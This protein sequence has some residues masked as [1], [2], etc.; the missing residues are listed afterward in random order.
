[1]KPFSY[2][3]PR[4]LSGALAF[5]Q[6]YGNE[7]ILVAGGT[8][9]IVRMKRGMASPH[10]LIDI[11]SISNL[12]NIEFNERDG[13]TIGAAA[14]LAEIESNF[15]IQA[16][17]PL[18]ADAARVIGSWQTRNLGTIGGNICNAS[19]A[20]DMIPALIALRG[21]VEIVNQEGARWAD[22]EGF[23][24]GP[25]ESILRDSEIVTRIHIP[26]DSS[27]MHGTYLKEARTRGMDLATVG[28]AVAINFRD[29][30]TCEDVSIVLGAVAPTPIR[31]PSAEDMLKGEKIAPDL[32]G[33]ASQVCAEAC[34][35]ITDVRS[36]A[37]YRRRLV[38][39]L[40]QRALEKVMGEGVVQE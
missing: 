27:V 29:G 30:G 11:T 16:K 26:A 7:A 40:V 6:K 33:K 14:C 32:I 23:F 31:V 22:L 13:L 12:R 28:V 25:G 9:L 18:I 4:S 19:P 20:G 10:F 5:L 36:S 8:D 15:L 35:P 3:R 1:M 21:R 34:Q 2:L 39:V 38:K 24:L 37:P 17:F